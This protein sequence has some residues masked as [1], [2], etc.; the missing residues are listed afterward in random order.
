MKP[1]KDEIKKKK[2]VM[3]VFQAQSSGGQKITS[4]LDEANND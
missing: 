1:V 3:P 2:Y 4:W